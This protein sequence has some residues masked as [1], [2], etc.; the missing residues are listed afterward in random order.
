VAAMI[1]QQQQPT[2][3]EDLAMV[4]RAFDANRIASPVL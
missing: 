2:R 1:L 4:L 3:L